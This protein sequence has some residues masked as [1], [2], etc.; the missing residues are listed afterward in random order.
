VSWEGGGNRYVLTT[1]N[2]GMIKITKNG[3]GPPYITTDK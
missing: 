1:R 2:D 3:H